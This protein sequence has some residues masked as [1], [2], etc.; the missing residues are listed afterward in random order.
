M[1]HRCLWD[2][3]FSGRASRSEFWWFALFNVIVAIAATIVDATIG[4][5]LFSIAAGLALLLPGLGVAV[6][7]LHD[8]DRTGWWVLIAL[9][10]IGLVVLIIFYA[11][12]GT[13]GDNEY[14]PAP[15]A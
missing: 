10:I 6:R 13:P 11:T 9:T 2:A 8:T 12:P 15:A 4:I 5:E 1:L 3:V 14:G 7:R